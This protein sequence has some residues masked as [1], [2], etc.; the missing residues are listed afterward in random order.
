MKKLQEWLQKVADVLKSEVAII[1]G[2]LAILVALNSAPKS[3]NA[4]TLVNNKQYGQIIENAK[5]SQETIWEDAAQFIFWGKMERW[6]QDQIAEQNS[7]HGE[8]SKWEKFSLFKNKEVKDVDTKEPILD[9]VTM[10]RELKNILDSLTTNDVATFYL[11]FQNYEKS[12]VNVVG[13]KKWKWN[14]PAGWNLAGFPVDENVDFLVKNSSLPYSKDEQAALKKWFEE[15]Y[16]SELS[17]WKKTALENR[18]STDKS[19]Y[20]SANLLALEQARKNIVTRIRNK[21]IQPIIE[22]VFN[23]FYST[24]EDAKGK[25]S[26]K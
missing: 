9:K 16:E 25:Q 23:Q 10:E 4:Q 2:A 13:N 22:K 7:K 17:N 15:I 11:A 18:K 20:E 8:G 19:L 1:T 24:K 12:G 14:L 26:K 21:Y 3:A 5:K 6:L